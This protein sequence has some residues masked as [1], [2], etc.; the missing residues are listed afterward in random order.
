VIISFVN[1][2]GGVGKSTLSVHLACWLK[3]RCNYSVSF[4]DAD[5]QS[6]STNWL[7]VYDPDIEL[8]AIDTQNVDIIPDQIFQLAEKTDFTICDG[9]GGLGEVTRTL[10]I[11]SDIAIFPITPSFLDAASLQK[12]KAQLQYANSINP[13]KPPIARVLLNRVQTRSKLA[14]ET[15]E[16]QKAMGIDMLSASVRDL[17]SFRLAALNKTV[18][19]KMGAQAVQARDDVIALFREIEKLIPV[20]KE[21]VIN[22]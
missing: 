1:Q 10:L 4:Y 6:S 22:G 7:R 13:A 18:V 17:N 9:P 2:K 5:A 21:M 14:K 3:E 8:L 19:W 16:A 11:L 15:R 20:K 12:A